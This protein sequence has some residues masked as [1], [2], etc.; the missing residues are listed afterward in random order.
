MIVTSLLLASAAPLPL[1]SL[2][3]MPT[4]TDSVS[5]FQTDNPGSPPPLCEVV[6][7]R[8]LDV[9]VQ[10]RTERG[11][12][13]A[14]VRDLERW[15]IGKK[16]LIHALRDREAHVLKGEPH[17]A[18]VVDSDQSYSIL[19]DD[20]GLAV[21]PVL[22]PKKLVEMVGGKNVRVAIPR[23]NTLL[24]WRSGSTDLDQ[25][26]AVAVREMYETS[27]RAITPMIHVWTGEKMEAFGQAKAKRKTDE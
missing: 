21:I 14:T 20:S 2:R 6:W 5:L 18:S 22:F 25:I 16:E 27:T 9:C 24:A 10:L 15:S 17:R 13:W 19:L 12:G 3:L 26:M 8:F 1:D 7:P 4:P 11:W 23:S